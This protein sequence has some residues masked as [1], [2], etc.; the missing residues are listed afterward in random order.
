MYKNFKRFKEFVLMQKTEHR[1][2]ALR[3]YYDKK[4]NE[5]YFMG[6][7]NVYGFAELLEHEK[8]I[9]NNKFNLQNDVNYLN[10]DEILKLIG[11]NENE[12]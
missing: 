3:A 11:E 5:L 10:I 12:K 1:A 7:N 6:D 4:R 9:I 8:A 2:K